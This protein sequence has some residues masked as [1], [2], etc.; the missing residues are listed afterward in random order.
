MLLSSLQPMAR[1]KVFCSDRTTQAHERVV[2]S[3][4]GI[5]SMTKRTRR[6]HSVFLVSSLSSCC[7]LM[8]ARL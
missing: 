7:S 1:R 8:K 5:R 6:N 3:D 2:R 4:V